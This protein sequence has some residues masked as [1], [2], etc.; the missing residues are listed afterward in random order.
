MDGERSREGGPQSL[1]ISERVRALLVCTDFREQIRQIREL[2]TITKD[3]Q[4]LTL[5]LDYTTDDDANWVKAWIEDYSILGQ[6][7]TA[8]IRATKSQFAKS[9]NVF[10]SGVTLI[11]VKG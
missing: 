8:S 4:A 6:K 9:V 7:R 2:E 11:E 1:D 10:C 5:T 3:I